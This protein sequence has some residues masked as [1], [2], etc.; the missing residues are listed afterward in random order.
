LGI[1]PTELVV[2]AQT[3]TAVDDRDMYTRDE[4]ESLRDAVSNDWDRCIL[5]LLLNTG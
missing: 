3:D 1:S 2:K 4:I 5:E